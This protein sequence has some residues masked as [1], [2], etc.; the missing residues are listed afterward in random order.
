MNGESTPFVPAALKL[1]A[2]QFLVEF[3]PT[4]E[5][6]MKDLELLNVMAQIRHVFGGESFL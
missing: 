6:P 4:L 2:G 3:L 5:L 1:W